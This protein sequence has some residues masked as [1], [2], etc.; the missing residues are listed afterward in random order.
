MTA[1]EML[2]SIVAQTAGFD[3]PSLGDAAFVR[4]VD[5][6]MARCGFTSRDEYAAAVRASPAELQNLLE[7]LVVPETW[8]FRD[9]RPFLFLRD[10]ARAARRPFLRV[11][12]AGCSTGE[13]PYSIA[14][15]LLEAGL[16]PDRFSIDAVDISQRALDQAMRA[17]YRKSAFRETW[18]GYQDYFNPEEQGLALAREV[19]GLVCFHSGNLVDRAFLQDQAPYDIV[20]CRNLLI[21]LGAEARRAVLRNL[22]RLLAMNGVLITG[23]SELP[24]FVQNG[25]TALSHP[26]CFACVRVEPAATTA[27]ARTPRASSVQSAPVAAGRSGPGPLRAESLAAVWALADEGAVEEASRLCDA[28][29][30]EPPAPADLY[31]LKGLVSEALDRLD[32]AEDWY[33]KALYLDPDH[34]AALLHMSALCDR[35][36]ERSTAG[37]FRARAARRAARGGDFDEPRH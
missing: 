23:A 9:R 7:E 27:D 11:L 26:A 30:A 14:I 33:R 35:R 2:R 6:R 16:R 5:A 18:A 22:E 4:S 1:D 28:L 12:S 24:V 3:I 17:I 10:W 34:Y 8:F 36:G 31:Y 21:Y 37:L 15:A 32:A 13:E 19:A 25:Y 20:F 29:L